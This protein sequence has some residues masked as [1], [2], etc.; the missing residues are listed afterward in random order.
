MLIGAESLPAIEGHQGS[1]GLSTEL[2]GRRQ[3]VELSNA[4]QPPVTRAQQPMP[5]SPCSA[6]LTRST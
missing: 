4:L 3:P 2:S 5:P 1:T 6:S